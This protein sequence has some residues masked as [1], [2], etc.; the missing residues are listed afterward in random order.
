MWSFGEFQVKYAPSPD[1][2]P[3]GN[4]FKHLENWTSESSPLPRL[5]TVKKWRMK[6][7]EGKVRAQWEGACGAVETNE[8]QWEGSEYVKKGVRG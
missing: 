4:G 5:N 3:H 2:C 7:C 1:L 8:A 6:T